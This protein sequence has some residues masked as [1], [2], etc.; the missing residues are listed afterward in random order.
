MLSHSETSDSTIKRL[1]NS[2][3]TL[4]QCPIELL[5]V[6]VSDTTGVDSSHLLVT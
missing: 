3:M 4:P 2:V 5:N 6:A 1:S